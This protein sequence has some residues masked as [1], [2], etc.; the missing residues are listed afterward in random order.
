MQLNHNQLT[1]QVPSFLG[2]L[3]RL[4]DVSLQN[5]LLVEWPDFAWP[6][7]GV[8]RTLNVSNNRLRGPLPASLRNLPSL[9]DLNLGY[10]Q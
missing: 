1:G 6:Q 2:Q 10:N 4:T 3:P 7:A 9:T 8:L 5:N